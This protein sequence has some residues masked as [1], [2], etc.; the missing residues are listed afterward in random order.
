V[1][2]PVDEGCSTRVPALAVVGM[3]R[4]G[5]RWMLESLHRH[6]TRGRGHCPD[7][8]HDSNTVRQ[9]PVP[10]SAWRSISLSR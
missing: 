9:K 5:G 7:W 1:D 8:W 6:E 2:V 10:S 4:P 3:R